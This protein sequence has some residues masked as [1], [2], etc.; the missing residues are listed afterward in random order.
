MLDQKILLLLTEENSRLV[1]DMSIVSYVEAA[2][3][4]IL[5]GRP[6]YHIQR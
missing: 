1:L 6:H 4:G 5:V 2:F 3:L